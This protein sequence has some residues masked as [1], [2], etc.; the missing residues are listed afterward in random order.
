[1]KSDKALPVQN[2]IDVQPA[3]ISRGDTVSD[4]IPKK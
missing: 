2:A 1:L 4:S 3:S